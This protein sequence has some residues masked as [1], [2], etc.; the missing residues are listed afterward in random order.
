MKRTILTVLVC[1]WSIAA[2]A[3]PQAAWRFAPHQQAAH[4]YTRLGWMYLRGI[5]TKPNP[6]RA[7]RY[8][9]KGAQDN[10]EQ[11]R[12]MQAS[13][14]ARGR[15]VKQNLPRAREILLDLVQNANP[16]AAFQLAM[17]CERGLPCPE[18]PA[19]KQRWLDYAAQNEVAPAVLR[20]GLELLNPQPQE[21]FAL[22]RHAAQDLHFRWAYYQLARAYALGLGTTPNAKQAVEAMQTAANQNLRAAQFKL[23]QWHEEGFGTP[24]NMQAS[25]RYTLAAA[26]NGLPQA[27]ERV[28][29]MYRVGQGTQPDKKQADKWAKLAQKSARKPTPRTEE[30]YL[31]K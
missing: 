16:H 29:Q 9:T 7:Y 22:I 24:A 17:W 1:L 20:K 21:G 4:P 3:Q 23:A 13:L 12:F 28:S 31:W 15:G 26:Q 10:D 27:Q 30:I 11:A 25:F 18:G 8:F 5:G 2:F 14:L 6:R 19:Q